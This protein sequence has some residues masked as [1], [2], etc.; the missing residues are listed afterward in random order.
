M[1]LFPQPHILDVPFLTC[2]QS[3]PAESM[4]SSDFFMPTQK[5]ENDPGHSYLEMPQVCLHTVTQFL[6]MAIKYAV[7]VTLIKGSF[8]IL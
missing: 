1:Q 5:Q 6:N 2:R 3:D 4:D 8:Q 7:R